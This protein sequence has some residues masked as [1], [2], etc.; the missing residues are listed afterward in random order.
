MSKRANKTTYTRMC[1]VEI[2]S[3]QDQTLYHPPPP[4]QRSQTTGKEM[5]CKVL[6]MFMLVKLHMTSSDKTVL[7]GYGLKSEQSKRTITDNQET[8]YD[9]CDSG[10]YRVQLLGLSK[11]M[12]YGARNSNT[13]TTLKQP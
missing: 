6:K 1:P 8:T 5:K 2:I 12:P 11:R 4:P 13:F 10:R 3:C 9:L 7:H